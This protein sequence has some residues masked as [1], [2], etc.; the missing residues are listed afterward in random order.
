MSPLS[1]T[2][3][4]LRAGAAAT[5]MH[6]H[7]LPQ[8]LVVE[9][10]GPDAGPFARM[11]VDGTGSCF[12]H[13]LAAIGNLSGYLAADAAQQAE[14]VDAFR[15]AFRASFPRSKFN[16]DRRIARQPT[17]EAEADSFCD[18]SAWA[19][20]VMIKHAAETLG[21]NLV[22]LDT[23]A[24]VLKCGVHGAETLEAVGSGAPLTQRT[25]MLL[26][27]NHSHFEPVVRVHDAEAGELQFIFDPR[28]E[29]DAAVVRALMARYAA[30]CDL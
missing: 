17:Y 28:D 29:A 3:A 30:Q 10:F 1:S 6:V 9:L 4:G 22:F 8:P 19:D 13:S 20:E 24:G 14:I 5:P 12:F 21:M 16:A 27:V 25:G 2:A 18:A 11:G 15:C 26:W 7:E 23:V